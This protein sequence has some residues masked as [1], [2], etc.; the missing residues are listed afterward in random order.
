MSTSTLCSESEH[1]VRSSAVSPAAL[2]AGFRV[3]LSLGGFSLSAFPVSTRLCLLSTMFVCI[4]DAFSSFLAFVQTELFF[5]QLA[6]IFFFIFLIVT[7]VFP[8]N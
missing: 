8:F 4:S 7:L 1:P 2:M 5:P 3:C 6:R